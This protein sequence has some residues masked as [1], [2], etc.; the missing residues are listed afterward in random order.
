MIRKH[1]LLAREHFRECLLEKVKSEPN[2]KKLTF[3]TT[4]YPVFQNV[5]N[6]L[7]EL[8]ILLTPDQEHKNVFQD[9]PV[10]GFH[11]GKSLKDHLAREVTKC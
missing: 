2:Q 4:F 5:K 7:Q 6:I 9:I 3:N 11:N 8:H 1:V 10:V